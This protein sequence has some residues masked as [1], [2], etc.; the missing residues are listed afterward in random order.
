MTGFYSIILVMISPIFAFSQSIHLEGQIVDKDDL[1]PIQGSHIFIHE[2]TIG[3][4]QLNAEFSLKVSPNDTLTIS[5]VGYKK[6]VFVIPENTPMHLDTIIFMTKDT[7][8]L[9]EVKIH[10]FPTERGFKRQIMTTNVMTRELIN[11]QNNIYQTQQLFKYGVVPEMDALD[12]YHSFIT[13]PQPVVFF[14]T[15]PS[16]GI[17]T[18]LQKAISSQ[19]IS[20]IPESGL[21]L[22]ES[23]QLLQSLKLIT[24][25][26]KKDSLKVEEELIVS[27]EDKK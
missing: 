27:E 6:Q 10:A 21:S 15:N 2:K 5:H 23:T 24:E 1:S 18:A 8:F 11:A 12:N 17:N 26:P 9:Q 4:T 16:M 19:S 25:T 20:F 7:T 14:S 22:K 13:G 3:A